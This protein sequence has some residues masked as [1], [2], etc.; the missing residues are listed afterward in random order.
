M[1]ME[2]K[3]TMEEN[4]RILIPSKIREHL[5]LLPGDQMMLVV[6]EVLKIIPL[7]DTVRKHQA[8][9]KSRNKDNISLVKSLKESRLAE[10]KNE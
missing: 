3:V 7:K 1:Y 8:F 4:G 9:I 10:F 6:D 2:L 5:E